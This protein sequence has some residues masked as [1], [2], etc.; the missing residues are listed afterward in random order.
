M[1]PVTIQFMTMPANFCPANPQEFISMMSRIASGYVQGTNQLVRV[2][3]GFVLPPFCPETPEEFIAGLNSVSRGYVEDT[4]VTVHVEFAVPG[5]FCW[6]DPS[7]LL[8]QLLAGVVA[9]TED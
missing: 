5:A 8:A 6:T 3:F 9:Y 7:G 1:T 2:E 4:G